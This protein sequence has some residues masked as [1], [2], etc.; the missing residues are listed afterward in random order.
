MTL[1]TIEPRIDPRWHELTAGPAGSVFTSPPW[2]RAVCS[3]YD[4]VPQARILIEDDRPTAGLAWVDVDDLR[5]HRLIS[6]PFCDRA[7]PI[8]DDLD[9][10]RVLVDGLADP[11]GPRFTT[12][13]LLPSPATDDPRFEQAGLA[14]WHGTEIDSN[15]DELWSK[16][17]PSAR[18]YVSFARRTG[19]RTEVRCDHDA[20][21]AFH[22]LHVLLRKNKYRLL[23][24]PA[25]LFSR[26]WTEFSPLDGVAMVGA[27]AGTELVAG[28]L[29]LQW[30]DVVYL[31]F[32]ASHPQWLHRHPNELV[33]WASLCHAHGRGARL[34]DWGL[35]DLEQP[36]LIA[37]KDKWASHQR[38]IR[39]LR[40]GRRPRSSS[41]TDA[42]LSGL[43]ALLTEPSVSDDLTARA[44]ALLYRYFC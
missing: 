44:G 9:T 4:F 40:S 3:T 38:R 30:Q 26:I 24:Q 21:L 23:A 13:T 19:L 25:Q 5:G 33:Y 41:R 36:G 16:L 27:Y 8:V 2:I 11:E 14:A 39:T 18:R 6:L 35:S 10:W 42:T 31:K 20:V 43:T 34:L 17:H 32:A 15:S 7:D 28:A 29:L 22:G 1:T 12:R 37:F